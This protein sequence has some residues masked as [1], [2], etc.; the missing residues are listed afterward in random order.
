MVKEIPTNPKKLKYLI[1]EGFVCK[2]G[3]GYRYYTEKEWKQI[4]KDLRK[5]GKE[6]AESTKE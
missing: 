4:I 1:D 5:H 2:D 6:T 3:D